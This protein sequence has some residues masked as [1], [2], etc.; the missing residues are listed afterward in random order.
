MILFL[1]CHKLFH[2]QYFTAFNGSRRSNCISEKDPCTFEV[3]IMR[4]KKDDVFIIVRNDP[5]ESSEEIGQLRF[6]ITTILNKNASV[7]AK[8][9]TINGTNFKQKA[10]EPFILVQNTN[11]SRIFGFV[12]TGF[13]KSIIS[14]TKVYEAIICDCIFV[15]NNVDN[16]IGM[17]HFGGGTSRLI[18]CKFIRNTCNKSALIGFF[19]H[20][21]IVGNVLIEYNMILHTKYRGLLISVNSIIDFNDIIIRNNTAPDAPLMQSDYRTNLVYIRTIIENNGYMN[22]WDCT[23]ICEINITKSVIKNNKGMLFSTSEQPIIE[24]N[25]T[26]IVNNDAHAYPLFEIPGAILK[27]SGNNLIAYNNGESIFNT[28]LNQSQV[29]IFNTQF[30]HNYFA[31]NA[32]IIEPRSNIS[33]QNVRYHNNIA[34]RGFIDAKDCMLLVSNSKF[35]KNRQKSFNFTN[36][37]LGSEF[38]FNLFQNNNNSY[39]E[40]FVYGFSPHL[41]VFFNKSQLSNNNLKS[42][43]IKLISS[44]PK[45]ISGSKEKISKET[46]Y[47][48]SEI[49]LENQRSIKLLCNFILHA[50][51]L[52]ALYLDR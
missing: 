6:L 1:L 29:E 19:S 25:D 39:I 26:K 28:V 21:A 4:V 18:N 2:P 3:A 37:G 9:L 46:F 12:F 23:G 42:M 30:Y 50:T 52:L 10:K 32:F 15:D 27:L 45:K 43:F 48:F 20:T 51:I 44:Y 17:V 36:I 5:V 24:I 33:F 35:S 49:Y 7:A 40:E 31:E 34:K 41:N 13:T 14:V 22:L 38:L 11:L 16:M 47:S 8:N